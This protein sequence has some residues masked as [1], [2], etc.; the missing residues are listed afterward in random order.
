M[1]S[2]I[3]TVAAA[4]TVKI[5]K[6][7]VKYFNQFSFLGIQK[8]RKTRSAIKYIPSKMHLIINC[9]SILTNFFF[10]GLKMHYLH[11]TCHQY[12]SKKN[13]KTSI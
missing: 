11:V 1:I 2:N 6:N 3:I 5:F 4:F 13:K 12:I 7:K 10:G 8:Y 9:C